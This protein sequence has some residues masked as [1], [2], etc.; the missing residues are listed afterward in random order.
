[1]GVATTVMGAATVSMTTTVVRVA[2]AV[3][4]A[5]ES[6]ADL[7]ANTLE[8]RTTTVMAAGLAVVA[9][10]VAASSAVVAAVAT[11]MTTSSAVVAATMMASTTEDALGETLELT[12]P[13]G[14]LS[15]SASPSLKKRSRLS[16][17]VSLNKS[18]VICILL[19]VD[20]VADSVGPVLEVTTSMRHKML[21]LVVHLRLLLNVAHKLRLKGLVVLASAVHELSSKV[22]NTFLGLHRAIRVHIGV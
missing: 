16:S 8:E 5:T 20:V 4:E 6:L 2:T 15:I 21:K 17:G 11:V 22:L 3:E 9:A 7:T 18:A 1:V 14:T 12:L 10:A 13:L 19:I